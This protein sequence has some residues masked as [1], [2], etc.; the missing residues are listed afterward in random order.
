MFGNGLV[1]LLRAGLRPDDDVARTVEEMLRFD[2][3]LQLFERTATEPVEVGGVTVQPGER[4]AAL[5][6]AANRDPAVFADADDFRPDRDPNPHLAFGVGVHFCLGAPLARMELAESLRLLFDR[7]P[8]LELA[9]EPISR[10]TFVLR[11][12]QAVRVRAATK[13][14]ADEHRH[15]AEAFDAVEVII[16]KRDGGAAVRRPDRLGG[17]RL[18]PRRRR[19]RADVGAG[20]GDPAQRH[21]PPRDRP[22]DRGDDRLRGAD[23]LLRALTPDRRQALDRRRRRQDHAAAGARWSRPAGSRCPSCPAAASATPAAP[24]T[25][26]SR[27]PAGGPRCPTRRCSPSSRTSVRSSAPPATGSR[28]PTRSSTRCA[29]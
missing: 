29:T 23:G 10:G 6:G 13:G 3:A 1:G 27:S 11:G 20:D 9:G 15:V 12:Y 17:R 2:S 19:R 8:G 5:L 16:A 22:L 24:S 14:V 21:G 18:H 25:S 28:R 4:I 7:F 26:S